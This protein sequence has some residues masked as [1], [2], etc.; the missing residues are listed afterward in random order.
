FGD[1]TTEKHSSDWEPGT[2]HQVA[3]VLQNSNQGSVYVDGERVLGDTKIDL[4]DIEASKK[5]SHFYIGGDGGSA[6]NTGR[7]DVSVTVENVLLYNRPWSSAEIAGLAK[8]EITNPMPEG[9]KTTDARPPS[10]AASGPAAEGAASQS[11]SG[12]Q[13]PSQQELKGVGG[14]PGAASTAATSSSEVTQTVAAGSGDTVQGNGSPQTPE[15]SGTSDGYGGTA[16]GTDAQGEG[17]H[18][19]DGEVNVTALNSSLG[20]LSRV[21]NTGDASTVGGSGLMSLLL[22][23]LWGVAAL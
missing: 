13:R 1:Q 6:D 5:I 22:L 12:G 21:N 2:T 20:S 23:G 17:I 4:I 7:N 18:A 19:E 10:P 3:I 9:T 8:K 15:V 16:G 14:E 11:Y